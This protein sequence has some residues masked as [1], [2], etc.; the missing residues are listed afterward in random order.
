ML[1]GSLFSGLIAQELPGPG[2]IYLGQTLMFRRPVYV[3]RTVLVRVACTGIDQERSRI[4]L[5]TAVEDED[6][7]TCVT[8]EAT[9]LAG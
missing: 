4:F 5:A 2:S 7:E 1:A 6:G 8:G 9:V 3:G